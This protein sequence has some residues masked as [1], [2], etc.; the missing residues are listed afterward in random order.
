MHSVVDIL[1]L[2][3]IS[4]PIFDN[5]AA[6]MA[7]HGQR[8]GLGAR[9]RSASTASG[10]RCSGQTTPGVMRLRER[11]V[12]RRPR[13]RDLPRQR[14][15]RPGDGAPV[16]GGRAAGR[17]RLHALRA[18]QL[19]D[20][21]HPRHRPGPAARRRPPRAAAGRRPRL[22]RL[23]QP[24]PARHG[25]GALPRAQDATSTTRWRRSCGSTATRRPSS[26]RSSPSASTR[27]SGRCASS[28]PRAGSRSPTPRAATS[29][30]PSPTAPSS[31]RWRGALRPD[32]PF[33]AVDA[34]VDDHEFADVVAE[35]YL[36]LVTETADV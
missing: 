4:R 18:G 9:A 35:R 11:L 12:A 10:S 17:R 22:R 8:R 21:R 2:N 3:G 29:G 7:G 23:L 16:R 13:A 25:A 28:R 15:R 5:A 14:R 6:A 36:S 32:I 34:H 26:A 1:G 27:P 31:T 24:G 20:G 30:T 33:E 19:A